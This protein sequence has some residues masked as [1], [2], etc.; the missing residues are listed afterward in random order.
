LN[1]RL[2]ILSN[3][4]LLLW[5][6]T[7]RDYLARNL[8]SIG[9]FGVQLEKFVDSNGVDGI[10]YHT[11]VGIIDIL[12]K[13]SDG[14]FYVFELKLGRGPDAASGSN[15]PL[16]GLGT[17]TPCQWKKSTRHCTRLRNFRET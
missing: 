16:Y 6:V 11:D 4:E 5:K 7:L 14:D 9:D 8:N 13:S 3:L 10:E 2:P 12:A 15:P 17:K 1:P